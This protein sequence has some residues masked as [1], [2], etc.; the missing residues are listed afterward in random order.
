MNALVDALLA[1]VVVWTFDAAVTTLVSNV[2]ASLRE[3]HILHALVSSSGDRTL[4]A[5]VA[6]DVVLRLFG[7]L[8][9]FSGFFFF[10]FGLFAFLLVTIL[11][12]FLRCLLI[13]G[14]FSIRSTFLVGVGLGFSSVL[15]LGIILDCNEFLS[16]IVCGASLGNGRLFQVVEVVSS[17]GF[18]GE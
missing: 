13:L 8:L 17:K 16:V 11:F 14:A 4:F 6:G 1:K 9:L 2:P 7:G 3:K 5:T 12:G 10:V 15:L 18:S